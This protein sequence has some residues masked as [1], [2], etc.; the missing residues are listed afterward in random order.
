MSQHIQ[1]LQ[2]FKQE[3]QTRWAAMPARERQL[4]TVAAWLA[5]AVLLVM[6]GIRPAWKTLQE[7]PRQLNELNA[8]LEAMR[9]QA[10]EVQS[11]RQRPP[12]PPV[13]VEAALRAATERLGQSGR[14]MI[15]GDRATLTANAVSGE[16]LAM[17]LDEIR[18]AARAK[19]VEANL[20]QTEPGRYSGT[21]I[22]ALGPGSEGR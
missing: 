7:T 1:T 13:Q 10:A 2:A 20:S 16:A 17:W 6:L 8:Q 19:P 18:A 5:G 3:W 9:S 4:V 21:V 11:L 14:L 12:V 22:L 15:Q